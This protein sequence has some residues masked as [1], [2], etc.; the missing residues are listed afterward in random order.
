MPELVDW[1]LLVANAT[2]HHDAITLWRH[3]WQYQASY[4]QV[5]ADSLLRLRE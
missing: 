1:V 4:G 3:L 2:L 5:R